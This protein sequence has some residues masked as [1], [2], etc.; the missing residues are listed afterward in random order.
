MV[1]FVLSSGCLYEG[2]GV[3]GVFDSLRAAKIRADGIIHDVT[4]EHDANPYMGRKAEPWT[5][6]E[7]PDDADGYVYWAENGD[8]Q[9][10]VRIRRLSV[11]G[12]PAEMLA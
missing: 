8:V 9:T 11:Q 4:E 10:F 6:S 12:L 7:T 3:D 5:I 2:G 1:V